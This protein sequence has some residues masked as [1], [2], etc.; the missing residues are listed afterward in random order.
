[1]GACLYLGG[2]RRRPGHFENMYFVHGVVVVFV[3]ALVLCAWSRQLNVFA[4]NHRRLPQRVEQ[5][6]RFLI[7]FETCSLQLLCGRGAHWGGGTGG[8]FG[9]H[10]S[11]F[12][13]DVFVYLLNTCFRKR[14]L[15]VFVRCG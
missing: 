11:V 3:Y 12:V 5:G 1:M 7:A 6:Q 2:S 15:I 8:K 10:V 4:T 14:S 9:K 13:I